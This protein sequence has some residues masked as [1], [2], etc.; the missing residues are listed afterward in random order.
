MKV[1]NYTTKEELEITE[2][3]HDW[4]DANGYICPPHFSNDMLTLY[5][6]EKKDKSGFAV[7]HPPVGQLDTEFLC[8]GI[9]S[10]EEAESYLD[11]AAQM[12][13]GPLSMLAQMQNIENG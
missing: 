5:L 1:V 12:I 11:L 4:L 8:V 2:D 13:T 6:I 3:W 9:P 10:E 7:Y